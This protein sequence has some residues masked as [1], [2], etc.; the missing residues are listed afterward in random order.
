[1][2]QVFTI[3][4]ILG[5]DGCVVALIPDLVSM[6]PLLSDGDDGGEEMKAVR[7]S[8]KAS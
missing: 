3:F 6:A 8:L 5:E 1:M 2:H 4:L 7:V